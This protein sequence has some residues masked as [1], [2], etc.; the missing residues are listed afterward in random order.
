M[1][2]K[3]GIVTPGHPSVMLTLFRAVFF[4]VYFR[5][6]RLNDALFI[7]IFSVQKKCSLRSQL[8]GNDHPA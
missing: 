1:V 4:N 8:L 2:Q 5:A 3:Y 7:L 6:N